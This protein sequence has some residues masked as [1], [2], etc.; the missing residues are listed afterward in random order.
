MTVE[1]VDTEC[2]G[3]YPKVTGMRP[4]TW[5]EHLKHVTKRRISKADTVPENVYVK[6]NA[7]D[8]AIELSRDQYAKLLLGDASS[9]K[10]M[11]YLKG[12]SEATL[13]LMPPPEANTI[14]ER[15]STDQ[16]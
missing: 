12:Q 6:K 1:W 5:W 10:A 15:E 7:F 16:I 9:M 11:Q 13:R 14:A 3:G 8:I 2:V 4:M